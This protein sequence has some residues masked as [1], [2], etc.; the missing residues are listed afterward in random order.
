[1][2]TEP[3]EDLKLR[4]AVAQLP[5]DKFRY[6]WTASPYLIVFLGRF[7]GHWRVLTAET[8]RDARKR[9]NYARQ[10]QGVDAK[11]Y[12]LRVSYEEAVDEEYEE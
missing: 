4:M 3:S 5:S 9:A 10:Y 11:I 1:M 2:T 7:N 12:K 8:L 6:P